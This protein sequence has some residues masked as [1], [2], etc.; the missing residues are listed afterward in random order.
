MNILRT[1]IAL[2]ITVAVF[3]VLCALAWAMA[4]G[5]FMSFMNSLFH[6]MDFSGLVQAS[7]F[8]WSGF[9]V[10]LLVLSAWAMLAG[11]FFCLDV[12]PAKSLKLFV[13]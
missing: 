4:P 2:S 9:L 7:P 10:V 1:G 5:P 13:S 11:A 8:S 6:G 3:Y 12:Q